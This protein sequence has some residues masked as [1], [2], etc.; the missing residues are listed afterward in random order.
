MRSALIVAKALG[1]LIVCSAIG[2]SATLLSARLLPAILN[3]VGPLGLV[4]ISLLSIVGLAEYMHRTRPPQD[5]D[6]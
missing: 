3:L 1:M 4:C 2:A 6:P 5:A